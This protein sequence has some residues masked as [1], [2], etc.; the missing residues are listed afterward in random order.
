M[1]ELANVNAASPAEAVSEA[2]TFVPAADVY[3]T[4]KAFILLLDMPGADPDTL[5][6]T[7]EAAVLTVSARSRAVSPEGYTL[8]YAEYREGDYER[9]FTLPEQVDAERTEAVFKDGV[10]RLTIGKAAPAAKKISVK[11]A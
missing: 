7:L 8:A 11:S 10:L 6:V 1:N 4:P 5:N 9:A 2:P 3:E